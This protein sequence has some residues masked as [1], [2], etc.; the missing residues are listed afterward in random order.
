MTYKTTH[1]KRRTEGV[2]TLTQL[3][4]TPSSALLHLAPSSSP[5]LSQSQVQ[6]ELEQ[7]P[8]YLTQ[9][10]QELE[11]EVL[12]QELIPPHL[13]GLFLRLSL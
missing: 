12:V 4:D 6:L 8:A 9:T 11:L 3:W 13:T 7:P 2:A 5:Q 10:L 1:R